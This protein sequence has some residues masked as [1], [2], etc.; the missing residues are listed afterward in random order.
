MK[1]RAPQRIFILPSTSHLNCVRK[2]GRNFTSF[3]RRIQT[4]VQAGA[5]VGGG[6]GSS[7]GD[8]YL[9][10]GATVATLLM[11]GALHARR[12]YDDKKVE[13]AR[14][15][16]IEPEFKSDIKAT[17]LRL[18]PL[19]LVSRC[20]GHLTNVELPV[21]LRPYVHRA[22]ARA[23][24]SN[25]E[26]V[27]LPLDEYAS[28]RE[29]FIRSLKEGCRPIDPDL[30]C[31][32]SPVDGT[33]LRF[34]ELKGAGAMIEQ[35]KGFS[36]SVVALLGAGS[37]LPMMAGGDT[38]EEGSGQENS[39]ADSRKKSWWKISLAYPKVL[40]PVSTCPVKGLFYCVIY[41][42]P[43]DY[44]RIHSPVDWQVLVRRHFSGH[45]FPMNERAVRTIRNLYV[46]NERVVL[47]GLWQE[48]YMA[49]AAIGATNIGSIKLFI[50]PELRTN[51]PKRGKS[52]HSEPPE[53][54]V[55]EPE[56]VGITLKKGDEMAAFNMGS[57]V[58]LVF[59]AP[60]SNLHKNGDSKSEFKFSIKRGDRIRAGEALGR[61]A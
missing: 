35:V 34:G 54:R 19:R 25:L 33:V 21:W 7:Q 24:H 2:H 15:R 53:E 46:E 55:Y 13:E 30:Q 44:H 6:N 42:K 22:W 58:V 57:T 3:F 11:L 10:P 23:F 4:S 18:I 45:L 14:E 9:V 28:L 56:G 52:L 12:L 8:S 43:G 40:D 60:V 20:W 26:E 59:Q 31:L 37:L 61:W 48:G 5:S 17:F 38:D 51:K 36:Y 47:E 27:A 1:F 49:I 50:E 39:S 16:G 32:V 29:F 41:L